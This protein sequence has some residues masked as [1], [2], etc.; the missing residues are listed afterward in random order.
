V[1]GPDDAEIL[2]EIF[3]SSRAGA[4]AGLP[5]PLLEMQ[6]RAREAAYRAAY[7]QAVDKLIVIGGSVVGRVLVSCSEGEHRVVDIAIL[8]RHQGGGVGTSV[9]RSLG[10]EASDAGKPLRLIAAA[11]SR[12]VR[13]YLRIGFKVVSSDDMNLFFELAPPDDAGGAGSW[14]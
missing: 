13:L 2:W 7:P 1:A 10:E 14:Q 3:R 9:L 8:P 6:H 12:A 4:L 11:D 5:Q